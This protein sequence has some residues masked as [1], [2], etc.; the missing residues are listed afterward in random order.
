MGADRPP[1]DFETE[2]NIALDALEHILE[3]AGVSLATVVR[4]N[5]YLSNI[6]DMAEFN[7][8]YL[9]RF[10]DLKPARYT[11]QAWLAHG[12]RFEI[13]AVAIRSVL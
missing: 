4:T 3:T 6:D 8:V 13:D 5:C 9:K 1:E 10:G 11:I 12:L 7:A 2:I